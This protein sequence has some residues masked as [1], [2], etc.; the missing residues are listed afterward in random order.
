MKSNSK[1]PMGRQLVREF[2]YPIIVAYS[3]VGLVVFWPFAS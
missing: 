1:L 3:L 2:V